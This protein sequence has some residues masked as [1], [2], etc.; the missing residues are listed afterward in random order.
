MRTLQAAL[1]DAVRKRQLTWNPC[2]GVELGPEEPAEGRRWTPAEAA[3]FIDATAADPVGLMF[4]IAVL[5]GARRSELCGFRWSGTDLDRGVLAV[6]RRVLQLG[7]KLDESATKT[8]AGERLVFL[9]AETA[10]LLREHRKAQAKA[11]MAAPGWEITTWCSAS[12]TAGRGIP[13]T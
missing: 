1:N 6:E 10:G 8:R 7:G 11:R 9:D 3:R 13:T 12:R 5:R 2:V 4:R